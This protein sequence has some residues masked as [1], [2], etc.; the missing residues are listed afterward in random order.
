M[1]GT[2][3]KRIAHALEVREVYKRIE[4]MRPAPA[5]K[6]EYMWRKIYSSRAF[7]LLLI[8]LGEAI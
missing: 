8:V 3:R 5:N 2:L 1:F 4:V 6:A 7:T